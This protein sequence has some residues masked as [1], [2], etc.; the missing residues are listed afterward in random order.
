MPLHFTYDEYVNMLLIYGECRKNS[1]RARD[2]YRERFPNRTTPSKNTFAYVEQ[3]LRHGSFPSGKQQI[4]RRKPIQTE[5]NVINILAYLQV[6]P[7]IS[8]RCLQQECGVSRTTIQRIL[9]NH[10][11]HP[12]KIHLTQGLTPSDP[13]RRLNFIA[14]MTVKI[15]YDPLFLNKILWTDES[16]FHNNGTVNRHNCHYWSAE[17]PK[18]MRETNFQTLW[19]VNVWCGLFNGRL[20]GPYLYEG[21]LTGVRYLHILQNILPALLEDIPLN[22]RETMWWQQDGA[23]PH[24]ARQVTTYL[25]T[26]FR[27]R[28]IGRNGTIHWPARSPDMTPLDF[29]LWGYLKGLVYFTQP[30]DLDDLQNKIRAACQTVTPEMIR[31]ACTRNLLTRFEHCITEDGH[32]FEHQL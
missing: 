1:R 25:D 2:L 3:K 4:P 5:D 10:K 7:H 30:T 9:K 14:E 11:Y 15:A 16:R 28:W 26:T 6:N 23:P 18:W 27:E 24:Y 22:E 32:Q 13:E 31:T 29:F 17:N 8:T 20:I 19:G 12:F 21:T